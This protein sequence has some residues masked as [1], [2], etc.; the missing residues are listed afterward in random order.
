[1]VKALQFARQNPD[2]TIDIIV[3]ETQL[4]KDVAKTALPLLVD[5]MYPDDPGGWSEQTM[6]NQIDLT[7]SQ[8]PG[9]KDATIDEV[10]DAG[11]VREAQKSLGIQC[12]GGY[13]C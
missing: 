11:P 10:A 7:R 1:M 3:K 8:V 13:K 9:L 2:E 12:K 5:V 4:D 6:R